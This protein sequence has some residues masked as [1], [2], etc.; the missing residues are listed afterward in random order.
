M[1]TGDHKNFTK[2]L[3]EPIIKFSTI[4]GHKVNTQKS[5]MFLYTNNKLT[6]R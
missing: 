5:I 4:A 6:K 2:I 3:L 1:Y